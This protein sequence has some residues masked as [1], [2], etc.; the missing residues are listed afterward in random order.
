MICLN[1]VRGV[2]LEPVVG[3]GQGWAGTCGGDVVVIRWSESGNFPSRGL[4][5][6]RTRTTYQMLVSFL[7]AVSSS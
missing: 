1:G 5:L 3:F 6:T 4:V 7:V 2:G